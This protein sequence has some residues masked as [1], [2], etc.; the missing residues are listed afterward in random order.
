MDARA[1]AVGSPVP[2]LEKESRSLEAACAGDPWFPIPSTAI[3][4]AAGAVNVVVTASAA[5]ADGMQ[6]VRTSEV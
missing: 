4:S 2:L 5:I 3:Q 1:W 6:S